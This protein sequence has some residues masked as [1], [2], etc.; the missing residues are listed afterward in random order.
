MMLIMM[1]TETSKQISEYSRKQLQEQQQKQRQINR[2][3]QS[4]MKPEI[5]KLMDERRKLKRRSTEYRVLDRRIRNL[6][7]MAEE[8][9]YDTRCAEIERLERRNPQKMYDKIRQ[10]T[11]SKN[12]S[13]SCIKAKDGMMIMEKA[14]ILKRWQEYISDLFNDNRGEKKIAQ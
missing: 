13:A 6:C 3:N 10:M 9:L 1:S 2:A 12:V 4:W 11:G 7:Q 5:L 14:N 8:E